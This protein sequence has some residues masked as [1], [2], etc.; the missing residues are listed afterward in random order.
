MNKK[1]LV[2]TVIVI[3]I[4]GGIYFSVPKKSN[5]PSVSVNTV[6]TTTEYRNTQYS[7]GFTLPLSWTG[8]TIVT[9]T[10]QGNS[11]DAKG[12]NHASETGPEISI[13]NP[14]W[15]TA[16]PTQ[17]I[18]IMVFTLAQWNDMQADKFHIG[19]APIGPSELGRNGKYVFGL[20]ARYNFA[21]PAGFEEVDHLIQFHNFH[22][23]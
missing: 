8:Y 5:S 18:P 21:F 10:W 15:T 12:Q 16:V 17:D 3:L 11:L 1:I 7:F 13:R 6:A 22:T 14:K 4:A 20:P 2:F 23:F 19:A 9:S